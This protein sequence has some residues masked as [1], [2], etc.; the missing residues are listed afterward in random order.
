MAQ[1][2][3]QAKA[4][5]RPVPTPQRRKI[6]AFLVVGFLIGLGLGMVLMGEPSCCCKCPSCRRTPARCRCFAVTRH[7][8]ATLPVAG[9]SHAIIQSKDAVHFGQE[10]K[11]QPRRLAVQVQEEAQVNA[12]AAAPDLNSIHTLCTGNGSPYQV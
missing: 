7:F 11:Q 1:L 6:L 5:P 3:G 10:S 2:F 4:R 9:T 12:A 8:P